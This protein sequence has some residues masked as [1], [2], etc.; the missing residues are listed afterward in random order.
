MHPWL[1][2]SEHL[3]IPTYFT[4][5]MAGFALSTLVLRREALRA[6]VPTQRVM[7][8]ALW[9]TPFALVGARAAHVLLVEPARYWA[10]PA[11]LLDLTQSG[12]VFYGGLG[13]GALV[14]LRFC[15]A[16]GLSPWTMGDIFAPAT[17]FGLVFGRLG[18]L[19]AGCCYGKPTG[20]P[21]AVRYHHR[22]H[23]PDE[24]LATSLHPSP[25]YEAALA[26]ALFVGLSRLRARGH[27]P[28][29]VLLAFIGAY[30]LGRAALEVLRADAERGLYLGGYLSTSQIIG[31]ACAALVFGVWSRGVPPVRT[32]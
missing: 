28:G 5:L 31:L 15:R 30:G 6:G 29:Q 24:L 7:D 25:L 11:L 23:I 21:W 18:C 8:L 17:A 13:A 3:R 16:H 12:L 14:L 9:T 19:G 10:Q 1:F 27:A 4:C 32:G 2:V 26:L 20:L 22:G